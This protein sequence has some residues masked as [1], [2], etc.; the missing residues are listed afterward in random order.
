MNLN[1]DRIY[2]FSLTTGNGVVIHLPD[3][4][5][6]M[7]V[8]NLDDLEKRLVISDRAHLGKKK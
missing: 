7:E 2:Y 1:W 5:K 6:E 8:N 3:L 4:F